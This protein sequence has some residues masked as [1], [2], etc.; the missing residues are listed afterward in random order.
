MAESDRKTL[1][2]PK[3]APKPEPGEDVVYLPGDGDPAKLIWRGI[4][5]LANVAQRV[6][7]PDHIEAARG[8]RYF[9]VGNEG[10]KENPNEGPKD[11]MDYRGYV[12]EWMKS[13]STIE[14][15]VKHWAADRNLRVKCEVG[16]DDIRYLGT[17][18]EPKLRQ[19]RLQAGLS[20]TAVA[21]IWVKHGVLDLPWRA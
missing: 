15:L 11:S 4:E 21:D 17:L 16:E 6:L 9:R 10:P 8:N 2:L 12:L 1:T 19:M 14:D 5:F 20:D 13:V 18:I 7:D 3:D